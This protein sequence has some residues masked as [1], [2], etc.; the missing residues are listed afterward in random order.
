MMR[1]A[2]TVGLIL[3]GSICAPCQNTFIAHLDS[4]QAGYGGRGRS[5]MEVDSGFVLFGLKTSDD[6]TGR[7]R[8][9]VYDL[10]TLGR[11]QSMYEIG[12]G[13]PFHSSFGFFDPVVHT[14]EGYAALVHHH[15]GYDSFGE[16][17]RFSTSGVLL[18]AAKVFTTPEIDSVTYGTRQLRRTNDGGFIFC[19]FID[20]PDSYAKAWLVKLDSAGTIQWEQQYGHPDQSYE[21]IS[22]A[23]YP[24]GGYVLAGYRLPA[25][26]DD[27]SF[28]IRTDSA[29]NELWRRYFDDDEGGWGLCA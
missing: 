3:A 11:Y 18:S 20:P 2:A 4:V 1:R 15:A 13:E 17:T 6:G 10:D 16:L 27:L 22:V 14:S 8:C 26:I 12:S 29:G 21:A 23:Q 5:I 7:S 9:V 25:N 19:G 24:D 28:L